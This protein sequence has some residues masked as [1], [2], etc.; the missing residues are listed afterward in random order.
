MRNLRWLGGLVLAGAATLAA[1]AVSAQTPEQRGEEIARR[2][3]DARRG[4]TGESSNME[5]VLVN[6]SGD[7]ISRRMV[8]KVFEVGTDGDRSWIAFEWPADVKGTQLLTWT[9]RKGDDD[10]WLYLPSVK[11][12]KRISS[13][14]KSGSFMGSEFSYE[15]MGS[16]EVEKYTYKYLRDDTV[17]GRAAWV[18]ERYPVDPRS[19]YSKQIVWYDKEYMGPVRID[20]FDRKQELLKTS[21]FDEYKK[22]DRWWRPGRIR[23]ENVQTKKSSVLAWKNRQMGK[24]F[25][26]TEFEMERLGS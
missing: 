18:I 21:I 4:F 12:V 20:Y 7:R 25:E 1:V 5:L 6:A 13:R 26:P 23:V 2:I 11:R 16:Q 9:H 19:G 15:D 10:Q 22:Y 14:N 8:H 17:D 24:K 3:Y